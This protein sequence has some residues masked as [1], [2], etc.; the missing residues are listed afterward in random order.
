MTLYLYCLGIECLGI[1][2]LGALCPQIFEEFQ[3]RI[4]NSDEEF[5]L[6]GFMKFFIVL[7][8]IGMILLRLNYFGTNKK[9]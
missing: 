8:F 7:I 4:S 1:A 2:S 3:A 6:D 5:P 9:F